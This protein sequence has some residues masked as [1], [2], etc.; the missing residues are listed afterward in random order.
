MTRPTVS[1]IVPAAMA[2]RCALV[3][4]ALVSIVVLSA[5]PIS[6]QVRPEPA[7]PAGT[8]TLTRTEYDRLVDLAS[9]PP[10][11]PEPGPLAAALTG[12][13]LRVTVNG[14]M[15]NASIQVNG[16]VLRT[17]TVKVPLI[18]GATLLSAAM[19]DRALP[20]LAEGDTHFAM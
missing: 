11:T 8:V 12:A 4:T 20:L 15:A 16:D 19:G 14:A 18:S 9:R 13:R 2:S 17:G 5:V 3:A 7:G 10:T 1:S 6:A